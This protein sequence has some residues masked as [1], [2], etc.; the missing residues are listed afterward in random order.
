MTGVSIQN[1]LVI[2][3]LIMLCFKKVNIQNAK[4]ESNSRWT[5]HFY[6]NIYPSIAV[7]F[8]GRITV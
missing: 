3:N 8:A 7:H 6:G 4:L 1:F 5:Y 2:F